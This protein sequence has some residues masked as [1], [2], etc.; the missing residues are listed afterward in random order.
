VA[1]RF[2]PCLPQKGN[3][4]ARQPIAY[5]VGLTLF[6]FVRRFA[7]RWHALRD[8]NGLRING[9]MLTLRDGVGGVAPQCLAVQATEGSMKTAFVVPKCIPVFLCVVLCAPAVAAGLGAADD[10][11][12]QAAPPGNAAQRYVPNAIERAA[13]GRHTGAILAGT[14]LAIAAYGKSQWWQDGFHGRFTK[15]NEGWFGQ[16]TYSGGA[17]KLGHFYMTYASSRLL[18]RAF[19]WD[20][21]SHGEALRLA[22]WYTLGAFAAIEV[23]DGY[24]RK[25]NFSREDMVMNAAGVG[26]A[27]LL[28]HNPGLD[29]VFD[30]RVLYQ[31]SHEEGQAFDP[32]GDYSGQTYLMVAKLAGVPALRRQGLLR[33][34]ELAVGYGTRGYQTASKRSGTR[35]VYLG[36]SLNLSQLL[37]GAGKGQASRLLRGADLALELVQVPGTALLAKH[38]L[39]RGQDHPGAGHVR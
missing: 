1:L 10:W 20:G 12:V 33:Y 32:F 31:P 23:L 16:E 29:R 8:L 5:M 9:A 38:S 27:V 2:D 7:D 22:A 4:D 36:V 14:S 15:V 13:R 21:A 17:D 19:V 24:S 28:E 37:E 35:N 6:Q 25:W 34:V 26:A 39:D 30:L 18:A 11:Q 3:N